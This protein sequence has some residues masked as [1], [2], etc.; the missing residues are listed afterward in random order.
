V[1]RANDTIRRLHR[2]PKNRKRAMTNEWWVS[3][4]HRADNLVRTIS[5]IHEV[6]RNCTKEAVFR[7]ASC[8]FVDRALTIETKKL[9]NDQYQTNAQNLT[10]RVFSVRLISV[11]AD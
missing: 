2:F 8:D 5:T 11:I 3:F 6:T 10:A 4:H 7:D 1:M 9:Q